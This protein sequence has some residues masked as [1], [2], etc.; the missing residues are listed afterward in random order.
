MATGFPCGQG[1]V[2]G[3]GL[4]GV[5]AANTLLE[6]NA[7]VVLLD[8]SSFC[9]GNSSKATSGINGANTKDQRAKNIVDSIDILTADT[10]KAARRDPRLRRSYAATAAQMLI[11]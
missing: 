6:N 10:H 4:S 9:G 5:S 11:G 8:K 3:G 1:I 2:V 7:K